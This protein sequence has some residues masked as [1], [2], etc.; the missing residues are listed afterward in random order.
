M[1]RPELLLGAIVVALGGFVARQVALAP[2]R[3]AATVAE[4]TAADDTLQRLADDRA[5]S[6]LPTD[7]TVT[8]TRSTLPAP[9]RDT[10]EIR[11]LVESG[12][13]TTYLDEIIL[14]R[15]GYVARW[16]DRRFEPL[17]VWIQPTAPWPD[18]EPRFATDVQEAFT[19][20]APADAPVSFTFVVDSARADVLVTWV[21]RL[22]E[23]S[24]RTR[25]TR[26]QHWWIIGAGIEL[27]V[28]NPDGTALGATAV[29]AVAIHEVGHLLG[30]D[31]TADPRNIMSPVVK[32]PALSPT[33]LATLRLL[34]R[35]PPG[36]AALTN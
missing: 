1:R 11:R 33:D 10:A 29:K 19:A 16:P 20:W 36:R 4:P 8:V 34:Y 25:W 18:F 3:R 9:V 17:R 31:H 2:P 26:D 7:G 6:G 12:R 23:A 28:H 15:G 27:G 14:R 24:G 5:A 30:L 35:L 32:V 21:D 22:A 13:G